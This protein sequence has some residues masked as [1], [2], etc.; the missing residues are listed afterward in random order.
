MRCDDVAVNLPDYIL[1]KIEPNLGNALKLTL[2]VVPL[3]GLSL[4]K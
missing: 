2:T 3:A 1:G 4:K